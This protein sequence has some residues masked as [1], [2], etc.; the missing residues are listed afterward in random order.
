MGIQPEETYLTIQA[1]GG[2]RQMMTEA[3]VDVDKVQAE[4]WTYEE[5]D[6]MVSTEESRVF[7]F[8]EV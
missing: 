4:G 8:S 5:E 6:T 2:N 1:L 3:G 7:M